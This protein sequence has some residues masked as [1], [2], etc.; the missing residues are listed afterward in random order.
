M[1]KIRR[2]TIKRIIVRL[3]IIVAAGALASILG[4]RLLQPYLLMRE[5]F[6]R[7][8]WALYNRDVLVGHEIRV[9]GYL[10]GTG[11]FHM[12]PECLP[13]YLVPTSFELSI[14]GPIHLMDC[15]VN[16]CTMTCPL[17][18]PE[19]NEAYEIVGTLQDCPNSDDLCLVNV[20]EI[21]RLVGYNIGLERADEKVPISPGPVSF[22]IE[23]GT[24]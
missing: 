1:I 23:L 20:A 13:G 3:L 8:G 24:P 18:K 22:P 12:F 16:Q 9:R 2:S 4:Y 15:E 11:P 21:N 10:H 17:F 19:R 14:D 7:A 5:G 6:I